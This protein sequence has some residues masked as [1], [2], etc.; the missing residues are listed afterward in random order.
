MGD[1]NGT[2]FTIKTPALIS[3]LG[4]VETTSSSRQAAEQPPFLPA[5]QKMSRTWACNRKINLAQASLMG[6]GHLEDQE[7]P[8]PPR[9]LRLPEPPTP[10][11]TR[12]QQGGR[13][14]LCR[15]QTGALAHGQCL[16][17]TAISQEFGSCLETRFTTPERNT[18]SQE[19]QES[20]HRPQHSPAQEFLP[21]AGT[22]FTS[23]P[24]QLRNKPVFNGKGENF[25]GIKDKLL[26]VL[27]A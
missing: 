23:T 17:L 4:R 2:Q 10:T 13:R 24:C 16:R 5:G 9:K 6:P 14:A 22:H 25:A 12:G 11:R 19:Q 26:G 20:E 1:R 15:R 7:T 3:L 27:G 18:S 8:S 21:A